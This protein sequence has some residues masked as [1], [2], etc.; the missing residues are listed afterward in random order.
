MY[1]RS[2]E[3]ATARK[4]RQSSIDLNPTRSRSRRPF[5]FARIAPP[6][7][8][9]VHAPLVPADFEHVRAQLP[10]TDLAE[11]FDLPGEFPV[12]IHRLRSCAR[13]NVPIVASSVIRSLRVRLPSR[14]ARVSQILGPDQSLSPPPPR[15]PPPSPP[16]PHVRRETFPRTRSILTRPR[17]AVTDVQRPSSRAPLAVRGRVRGDAQRPVPPPPRDHRPASTRSRAIHP[18]SRVS[19]R[20]SHRRDRDRRARGRTRSR[21]SRPLRRSRARRVN[22][23]RATR[24]SRR[25]SPAAPRRGRAGGNP[26]PRRPSRGRNATCG[27]ARA[28]VTRASA[29]AR[30]G[31]GGRAGGTGC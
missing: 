8:A 1:L 15:A 12:H 10:L 25:P 6:V 23:G 14:R 17:S 5:S 28:R 7:D 19:S 24:P 13:F 2:S 9:F 20:R 16:N 18:F 31:A 26:R 4:R 21:R 22:R 3:A 29:R 30:G 11:I 27:A